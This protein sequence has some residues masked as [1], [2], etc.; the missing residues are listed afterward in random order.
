MASSKASSPSENSMAKA[1]WFCHVTLK[2]NV[3]KIKD[4]GLKQNTNYSV[5]YDGFLYKRSHLKGVWFMVR[6]EKLKK[7]CYPYKPNAKENNPMVS[8]KASEMQEKFRFDTDEFSFYLV[9]EKPDNYKIAIIPPAY[10]ENQTD[11][12]KIA[13][14]KIDKENN[15]YFKMTKAEGG[16]EFHIPREGDVFISVFFCWKEPNKLEF[17][18]LNPEWTDVKKL[19]VGKKHRS[20]KTAVG[21]D[22]LTSQLQ[23]VAISDSQGRLSPLAAVVQIP[24]SPSPPP[25]HGG[26]GPES[27]MSI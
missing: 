8:L 19:T 14:Y 10:D 16:I 11:E 25:S 15:S 4:K 2:D 12:Y 21:L 1:E 17:K 24:P 13:K 27:G 22:D 3:E 7:S 23:R 5:T 6:T 20:H 18:G 26:S 9:D